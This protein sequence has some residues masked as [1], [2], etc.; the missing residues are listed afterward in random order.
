MV[1]NLIKYVGGTCMF[2]PTPLNLEIA[3]QIGWTINYEGIEWG[4]VA[5]VTMHVTVEAPSGVLDI[6]LSDG[7]S[8]WTN[9]NLQKALL[10]HKDFGWKEMGS[11]G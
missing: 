2:L 6:M 7:I 4:R 1:A 11:D 10:Q 9:A 3:P 5:K 8:Y